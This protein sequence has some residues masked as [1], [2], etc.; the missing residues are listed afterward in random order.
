MFT[1]VL[2]VH[3]Y[4]Q[5]NMYS[6][7]DPPLQAFANVLSHLGRLTHSCLLFA[8]KRMLIINPVCLSGGCNEWIVSH[9]CFQA[10]DLTSNAI[11]FHFWL[12]II[13]NV[14]II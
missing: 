13:M 5:R 8:H 3:N 11:L 7:T 4:Q 1:F 10:E 14:C 6:V 2:R 12:L 9:T